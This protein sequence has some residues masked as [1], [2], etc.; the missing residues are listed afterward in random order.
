MV[1]DFKQ[2]IIWERE[3]KSQVNRKVLS[4]IHVKEVMG[5]RK[6]SSGIITNQIWVCLP[7]CSKATDLLALAG[8]AG[9]CSIYYKAKQGVQDTLAL[10]RPEF[11]EGFQ[12][13]GELC[14]QLV[15]SPLIGW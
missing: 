13:K 5:A 8:G 12:E 4:R 6:S 14:G 1:L 10:K 2:S 3:V 15:E 9:K 11:Y 7:V